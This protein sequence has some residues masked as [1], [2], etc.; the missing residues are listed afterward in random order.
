MNDKDL[1]ELLD[2]W[3]V[4]P[5]PTSLQAGFAARVARKKSSHL[6]WKPTVSLRLRKGAIAAAVLGALALLFTVTQAFSKLPGIVHSSLTIPYTV[7]SEFV[8]YAADGS[9]SIDLYATS[10]GYN[11]EELILSSTRPRPSFLDDNEAGAG[12]GRPADI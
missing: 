4:P 9:S 2:V 3:I 11:G 8:R 1:D 7:D 6:Y 10:F 12:H 5:V